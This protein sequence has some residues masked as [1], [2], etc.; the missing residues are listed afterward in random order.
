MISFA[1]KEYLF[2]IQICIISSLWTNWFKEISSFF[3][4]QKSSIFSWSIKCYLLSFFVSPHSLPSCFFDEVSLQNSLSHW[5]F[6]FN[7]NLRLWH[8]CIFIIQFINTYFPLSFAFF[9]LRVKTNAWQWS[10]IKP[11]NRSLVKIARTFFKVGIPSHHWSKFI[12]S[13]YQFSFWVSDKSSKIRN[14]LW[15]F[16]F[17]KSFV[18][19]V[20]SWK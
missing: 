19:W 9:V 8:K 10:S 2:K 16:F 3:S 13:F 5:I 7:K 15:L 1:N 6:W 12:Q 4:W 18:I 11:F 14:T 17:V 20:L